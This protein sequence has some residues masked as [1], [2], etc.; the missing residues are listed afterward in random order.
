MRAG[1][2]NRNRLISTDPFVHIISGSIAGGTAAVLTAPLDLVKT[3]LQVQKHPVHL[4][5]S[6]RNPKL[7]PK[8]QGT[9]GTLALTLKEEGFRGWYKGLGS[10][11]LGLVPSWSIYFTTYNTFKHRL[12]E[13]QIGPDSIVLKHITAALGAGIVTSC[14]TNPLW[15]IKVRLQTQYASSRPAKYKGI[16]HAF[17][18]IYKEEGV[19]GFFKGLK[20]SLLGVSHVAIQFPLYEYSK[21]KFS[22]NSGDEVS[23]SLEQVLFASTFSKVV[24]TSLTYPHEVLRSRFQTQLS[25]RNQSIASAGL[26]IVRE[27]GVVALFR[28][29]GTNLVRVVPSCAV[30]FLVYEYCVRYFD[31][32]F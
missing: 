26:R 12:Y 18:T 1:S 24:A 14:A 10:Y 16:A 17:A 4:Y 25:W 32:Q 7:V 29:M 19:R 2:E 27:E 8:Y 20:V 11:L 3:R 30:T 31:E 5:E 23:I 9:L 21:E 13:T 28:G 22:Q 6:N 15:L